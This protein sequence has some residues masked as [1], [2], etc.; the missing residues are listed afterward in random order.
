MHPVTCSL[1]WVRCLFDRLLILD[2][3]GQWPPKVKIFE[4]VFPDLST[5]HRN[6]FH[7]QIWWKSAVAKLPKGS[8]DYHTK[9]LALRGT[10]HSPHFAQNA[11]IA[12]K[13]TWTLSPLDLSMYDVYRFWSRSAA[14]CRTY[15]GKIDYFGPKSQYNIGFQPTTREGPVRNVYL[16]KKICYIIRFILQHSLNYNAFTSSFAQYS[17]EIDS[18][19]GLIQQKQRWYFISQSNKNLVI[20]WLLV[21]LVQKWPQKPGSVIDTKWQWNRWCMPFMPSQLSWAKTK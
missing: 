12:P 11:P 13:I 3:E 7:V 9:K 16:L 18:Q 2:F 19:L 1:L 5:G 6:T 21:A 10:H 8:L 20:Y 15:S 4:N 17:S 14:I